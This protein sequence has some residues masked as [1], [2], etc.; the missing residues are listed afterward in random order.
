MKNVKA[1]ERAYSHAR[2]DSDCLS[3]RGGG[4]GGGGVLLFWHSER[5]MLVYLLSEGF[6][7]INGNICAVFRRKFKVAL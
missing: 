5:N 1:L 4:R 6:D 2:S 3:T 7:V